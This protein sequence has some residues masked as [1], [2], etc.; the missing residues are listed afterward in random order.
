MRQKIKAAL[1]QKYVNLGLD[2]EVFEGVASA[3]ET[4]ITE[5]TLA[6]Y[7]EGAE[8][9]LKKYQSIGDKSRREASEERKRVADLTAELND[10]KAKIADLEKKPAP[11]GNSEELAKL[12]EEKF[13]QVVQPLQDKIMQFETAKTAEAA[14][15]TAKTAFFDN[16]YAKKFT[17]ERD[18][19]WERTVEVN[20]LTGRKMDA[21]EL[22]KKALEYFNSSVAKKG[23][24]I[25]KPF[26]ADPNPNEKTDFASHVKALRE[27]GKLDK[28]T[29]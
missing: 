11:E 3:V 27:S 29:E 2:E 20:D 14:L 22:E 4:F 7:V 12:L 6:N 13:S 23:V 24:D 8:S 1:Q 19:A 10:A 21:A 17:E 15:T 5:D 18:M 25:T 26:V 28:Q 16:D 9:M